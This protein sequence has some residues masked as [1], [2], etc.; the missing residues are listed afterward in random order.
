MT[1]TLILTH[2]NA[3]FDAVASLL[4]AHKLYPQALP[5]L[6]RRL[7]RNVR[8]FLSLYGGAFPF[9]EARHLRRGNRVRRVILV[10]TQ[11]LSSVRGM[12]RKL[13]SVLIIDHHH[14]P[15]HLPPGWS[16]R[17]ETVGATTT[18]L[19]EALS[20]RLIAVTPQEATLLL[21]GIYEDTGSLLYG[22][23]TPRDVRAA[24]WL[25]E[26][27]ADL[28][29]VAD[30]LHHP[31]TPA[32]RRL[33]EQLLETSTT[34]EIEGHTV[35]V[36][37]A[38][39]PPGFDDEISTLAHK[40]RDLFDPSALFIF[41][42]LDGRT[43]MV[44]RST[45]EE[46]NVAEVAALFGGKGHARAAAALIQGEEPEELATRLRR[47]LPAFVHP[48][49]TV[50]DLMSHGV[51]TVQ[52]TTLI[53]DLAEQMQRTG[54]EGFPVVDEE[55][56]LVGLVTRSAVDRALR[57]G[58]GRQPVA[59][60]M[61]V[62]N[63]AVKPDDAA[64]QVRSLMIRTGWGQIPVV[65][66]A[67]QIIGVVTRTDLIRT[68]APRDDGD[69]ER[70]RRLLERGFPPALLAL[71]RRI[72]ELAQAEGDHIYF[73]GGIV[74]DLLL[75]RPT[76]DVD[77]VVEGDA[78]ALC[79]RLV[80]ALGGE[81]RQHRRFGTAKWL[82]NEEVWRRV[83]PSASADGLPSFIDFVTARTEFYTQPTALPIVERSSIKQ[84]L[85][86]RD[87]TINTLAISLNPG[88]WG[89]L[90]DFFGG[91]ADLERGIIRVLH[92]LS[93][94]EDPT[95]ILRAARFEARFGF[96]VEPRTEALIAEALPLLRRV[97]GKRLRHELDL[98]FREAEPEAALARLGGWGAL[99][100]IHPALRY[101]EGVAARFRRL[102]ERLDPAFWQ[103]DEEARGTLHW[104]LFLFPRE[105]EAIESLLQRLQA[106]HRLA[107]PLRTLPRLRSILAELPTMERP[108]QVVAA[109]EGLPSPLLA[110][111]HILCEDEEARARI[112]EYW[113]RWR[114]VR[115]ALTGDDLRAMGLPP[116]PRYRR[117]LT[118]LR[119]ARLDGEVKDEADER[120]LALR[121]WQ[122][123]A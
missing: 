40:V 6:P 105:P 20:S 31:L 95:R 66:E 14:P 101:D 110:A 77:I 3:D 11:R 58:M 119:A 102:R 117:I 60:I 29:V 16:F 2:E 8:A 55:G 69:R 41:V 49:L 50:R 48:R 5:V 107:D 47:Q 73:V 12:G 94:V 34:M 93:F 42:G 13:Q 103:L 98:I 65:D 91:R 7:N 92:S 26:Q 89:E 28:E 71:I 115:P 74:R 33:Y 86:R 81:M 56:H 63:V 79:R 24:A 67:G 36:A 9:V 122:E 4:G 80:E 123:A 62:G 15:D 30:F 52:T 32:Q 100:A 70:I 109:L 87:F 116:G 57:H 88:R 23:T 104:V 37:W 78:I 43:Q 10:D 45:T 27:G 44:A 61:E 68:A 108:S 99:A 82:L 54:H 64:G 97:S 17:G 21:L 76:Q 25:L 53:A 19:V 46:I 113:T 18:L 75:G 38:Q 83:A 111:A 51:R 96:R 84:D 72:G 59:R 114:R 1:T 106:P 85:H 118:A 39:A 120:A 112:A 121:L 35:V 22:S 90:L